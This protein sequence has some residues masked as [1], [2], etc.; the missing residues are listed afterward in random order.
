[1]TTPEQIQAL[2]A[3]VIEHE[4]RL[5]ALEGLAPDRARVTP[6]NAVDDALADQAADLGSLEPTL[7]D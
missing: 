4:R 1:M 2:V 7:G 3:T 5:C 6:W